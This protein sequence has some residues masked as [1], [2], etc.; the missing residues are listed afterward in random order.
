M[1]K[2]WFKP[3]LF[4]QWG[5]ADLDQTSHIVGPALH[6]PGEFPASL[7]DAVRSRI[8]QFPNGR[9]IEVDQFGHQRSAGYVDLYRRALEILSYL[10]QNASSNSNIVLCFESALDF[11][12]ATWA[13]ILGGFNCVPVQVSRNKKN[14]HNILATL[15]LLTK[16]LDAPLFLTTSE[17]KKTVA[18]GIF[19]PDGKLIA[20]ETIPTLASFEFQRLKASIEASKDKTDGGFLVLTSG[21]GSEPKLVEIKFST[22]L[23]RFASRYH[24]SS[25]RRSI[26]LFPFDSITGLWI[27]LPMS[28]QE[29]YFQPDRMATHP[30]DLLSIIEKYQI[31]AFSIS[32]S[33]AAM[34]IN[35]ARSKSEQFN[36]H[37]IKSVGF[38]AELIN[39]SVVREFL[40]LL[41]SMEANLDSIKF[42][43]G[44]TETGPICALQISSDTQIVERTDNGSQ[45]VP[46]GGCL[47]G[48]SL[49]VV[50][51]DDTL[52][53]EGIA[54]HVQVWS[55]DK[56]F[57]GYYKD[58][59]A[60]KQY[61]TRD[62]WF[63]TGDIG[64]IEAGSLRITGREKE[65]III[66]SKN[67]SLEQ[68][69]APLRDL[70]GIW[71][72][73][74]I[75][76]SVRDESGSADE[77]AL[78][79]ISHSTEAEF[80]DDLCAQMIRLTARSSGI[81]VKYLV[82]IKET[83]IQRTRTGKLRRRDLVAH[84]HK[85]TL[86]PY[87][88]KN[89]NLQNNIKTIDTDIE[90]YLGELWR[91]VLELSHAPQ[92]DENFYDI[93]GDSLASVIVM[94]EVEARFQ[95]QVPV[96]HSL[97]ARQSQLWQA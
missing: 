37:A 47:P 33:F 73:A 19:K 58:K 64:V 11:I 52:A 79:F 63:K 39:P 88:V 97:S 94:T 12:P 15:K 23:S 3:R 67:F 46:L 14:N 9:Y 6:L 49:R 36:L 70:N 84:F 68:I 10:K 86:K 62:G 53:S 72:S 74:V 8:N 22:L 56:L 28:N 18:D 75:A 32:P 17:L 44:M 71:Q 51:D 1:L 61:F 30:L 41:E 91:D 4:S 81:S 5:G 35:A 7:G 31:E 83:D 96:A 20:V 29:V 50:D 59:A 78:F 43:F 48:W 92:P 66:N 55:A 13:C 93:G 26:N 89:L 24:L 54:G 38:G 21:T 90:A 27:I 57:S 25:S 87:I 76:A 42:A 2:S 60:T 45:A 40:K 85:G 82:P 80:L 16:K 65:I 69:E 77:L 95:C 34:M